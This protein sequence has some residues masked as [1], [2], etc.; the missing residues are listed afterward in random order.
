MRTA[1]RELRRR[2]GRFVTATT[3][4]TLVAVL[5]MFLGGLLDGLIRS[6]TDAVR[7]QDGDLIVYASTSKSSLLRS[8]VDIDTRATVDAVPGVAETGGIG[9]VQLG[10][11][12]PGRGPRDLAATALFGYELAPTG[13]PDPP[14]PGEV[15][16]DDVLQADGVEEGM[17]LLLGPARSPVMV[18][19]FV[20]QTTYSGQGSLWAAP[21]TWRAVLSANRPEEQLGADVFQAL[22]VRTDD[23]ADVADVASTIDAATDGTTASLTVRQAVDAIPGVEQQRTVFNQIIGVTVAIA[24]LVVALFFA[25]LT[26]ER[27]GLYGVLKAIGVLEPHPVRRARRPGRGRHHR[28]GPPRRR[29]GRAPRLDHPARRH[30]PR[31]HTAASR[32]QRGA[33]ARRRRRRLC[34]LAPTGAAGRSG[35]GDRDR[36]MTDVLELRDVRKVYT[37]GDT[38]VVALG[39]ADLTVAEGEIVALVGPSGSGK[40]TLCSIAGGLLTPTSGTV[41][42]SGEDISGYTGKQLTAFRQQRV[43]FVFQAV[44]LVPFLTA[45]ENL[46]VVDELGRPDRR[47]RPPAGRRAARRPRSRRPGEQ[48]PVPA[49]GWPTTTGGHRPV[50]DERARCRAVRRTDQCP[51]HAAR[52]A[53]DDA[54]PLGAQRTGHR[55]DRRH[56]RRPHDAV[57]RSHRAHRGRCSHGVRAGAGGA[58]PC[59]RRPFTMAWSSVRLPAKCL[60]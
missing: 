54:D 15:Y 17:E 58:A 26:V 52:R 35:I 31:R 60:A 46:L 6:A 22:V 16:A 53:G 29:P 38:E 14:G 42:V 45:R 28:G 37:V 43:G 9:V 56:P 57:L 59:R 27:L 25:L 1:L 24:V 19:G 47:R 20:A 36:V 11:R 39:H 7:A 5:V 12:V 33:A 50:A 41:K 48:P 2:P 10:A 18:I 30:P 44:N 51:R 8:R 13:V 40:T 23:G 4:L 34:V 3:I 49:V 21:A 55:G 32:D